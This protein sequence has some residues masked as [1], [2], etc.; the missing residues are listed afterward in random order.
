MPR[1]SIQSRP[2]SLVKRQS[3]NL[4]VNDSP[5]SPTKQLNEQ[6]PIKVLVINGKCSKV[7]KSTL[8]DCVE[9]CILE[10]PN[11]HN[12]IYVSKTG[13]A[14]QIP[15]GSNRNSIISLKEQG[16]ISRQSIKSTRR[17]N[18]TNQ[19]NSLPQMGSARTSLI[20]NLSLPTTTLA[21]TTATRMRQQLVQHKLSFAEN[22]SEET[23]EHQ[24]SVDP[25]E[26]ESQSQ[27]PSL[28]PDEPTSPTF[29]PN[30]TSF[31]LPSFASHR[32]TS[33][34]TPISKKDYRLS[35]LVMLG[36]EY[37][38]DAFNLP[39]SRIHKMSA[40]STELDRIKQDLFHRYLWTQK[41]Q[42]S[43]RIR[44][45]STYTRSTTFVI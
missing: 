1:V 3:S 40:K 26:P 7:F 29:N 11:E 42:V 27:R 13:Q 28:F 2:N 16:T 45:I 44:P 32:I 9:D 38:A 5:L 4:D 33:A 10:F 14:I 37:F 15:L 19:Y 41:P 25:I 24:T 23:T 21:A 20:N 30:M 39:R 31:S 12:S 36:P 6:I 8:E 18:S 34:K 43:S 22:I 17:K 35:D